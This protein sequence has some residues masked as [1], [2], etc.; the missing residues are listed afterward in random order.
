MSYFFF[1]LAL[2]IGVV[3]WVAVAKD[4][5]RVEYFAKPATM[6]ALL[7]FVGVNGGFG[8][9]GASGTT[10]LWFTL[11]LV[12]SLAGD[13]FLMLPKNLFIYGLVAFLTTHI[14]YITGF[15]PLPPLK[16]PQLLV[17]GLLVLLMLLPMSQIYRRIAQGLERDGN[18]KLKLPVL[19]YSLMISIMLL[20]A[21]FTLLRGGWK[22]FHA[23]AASAGAAL[24]YLSDV[25]LAW[26]RFVCP[27]PNGRV[28]NMIAYHA[29]QLLIILGAALHFLSKHAP[30]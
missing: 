18:S 8:P 28:K 13:I 21:L 30:S 24:F 22:P 12:F 6:V 29:G 20:A 14:F 26:N 11:A 15:N 1:W 10:M 19:A 7:A 23:L 16:T 9:L 4:W 25:I 2:A 17:A 27:I 5:P 3:D